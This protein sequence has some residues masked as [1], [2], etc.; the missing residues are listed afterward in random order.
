MKDIYKLDRRIS[1]LEDIVSLTLL[2][3]GA[4]NMNVKDAVTGLDRFKNGIIVD[5]F[6]DH[7]R[8]DTASIYETASIDPKRTH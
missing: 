1:R 7:S 2:E 8:T 5:N 6:G 4:L 3:Q